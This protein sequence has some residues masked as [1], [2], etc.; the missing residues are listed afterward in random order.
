MKKYVVPAIPV[1]IALTAAGT[2]AAQTAPA[3]ASPLGS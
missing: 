1:L 3:A 2:L